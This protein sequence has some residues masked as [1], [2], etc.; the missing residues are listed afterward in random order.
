[1]IRGPTVR[2]LHSSTFPAH[3]K[4]CLCDALGHFRVS[5]IKAGEVEVGSS[6]GGRWAAPALGPADGAQLHVPLGGALGVALHGLRQCE[7]HGRVVG[8]PHPGPRRPPF[9]FHLNV[10]IFQVVSGDD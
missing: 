7:L 8:V 5:V 4:H 9:T 2:G 3:L 1:M 10:S 6:G